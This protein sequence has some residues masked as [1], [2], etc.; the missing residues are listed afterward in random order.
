MIKEMLIPHPET[1]LP[2]LVTIGK[3]IDDYDDAYILNFL[4]IL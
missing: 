3:L 1:G 4:F 2:T